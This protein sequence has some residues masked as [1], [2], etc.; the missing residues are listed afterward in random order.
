MWRD[1]NF[2][3][4]TDDWLTDR[5]L[6]DK[7]D[8]LTPLRA[9]ACG[10]IISCILIW[11]CEGRQVDS[12]FSVAYVQVLLYKQPFRT[13]AALGRLPWP[14]LGHVNYIGSH[15]L[16]CAVVSRHRRPWVVPQFGAITD[17]PEPSPVG[18][19]S[20]LSSLTSSLAI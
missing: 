13:G 16:S 5:R 15:Y 4:L 6:T 2:L 18:T 1:F 19:D 8:C 3:R 17:S 9:C 14:K 20:G 10:V 7:T 11:C 12:N